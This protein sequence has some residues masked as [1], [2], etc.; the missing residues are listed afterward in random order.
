MD[1]HDRGSAQSQGEC[2]VRCVPHIDAEGASKLRSAS[3]LPQEPRGA[4][5]RHYRMNR[6]SRSERAPVGSAASGGK[7][8][9]FYICGVGNAQTM[10][11]VDQVHANPDRGV[12]YRRDVHE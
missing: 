7:Q 2:V 5:C 9:K 3:L 10:D 12:G 8:M 1:G 4:R 11:E 6:C